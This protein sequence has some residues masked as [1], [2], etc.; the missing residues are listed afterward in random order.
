MFDNKALTAE[1]T[2]KLQEDIAYMRTNYGKEYANRWV[3]NDS[4]SGE[5]AAHEKSWKIEYYNRSR[6]YISPQGF[7]TFK[8]VNNMTDDSLE[9]VTEDS[10]YDSF[11]HVGYQ[12][13]VLL[14]DTAAIRQAMLSEM[15]LFIPSLDGK[16]AF[17]PTNITFTAYKDHKVEVQYS[18]YIFSKEE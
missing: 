9:K 5:L 1:E 17:T 12:D 16:V 7:A 10:I 13:A 14:F 8:W 11:L 18:G 3:A 2:Q 4:T 15:P 6:N